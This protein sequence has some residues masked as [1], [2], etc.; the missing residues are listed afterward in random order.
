MVL[1][2]LQAASTLVCF[3]Q[4]EDWTHKKKIQF[5]DF[6]VKIFHICP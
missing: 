3:D 6:Y 4:E 2:Q 5:D 1:V